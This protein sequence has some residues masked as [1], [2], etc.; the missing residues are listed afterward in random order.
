M[1]CGFSNF[2]QISQRNGRHC[3]VG[4]SSFSVSDGNYLCPP[5]RE[6]P[7]REPPPPRETAPPWK[8][9]KLP[10]PRTA[11]PEKPPRTL[12]PPR[13]APPEKLRKPPPTG[14]RPLKP[15]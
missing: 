13:T 9:R 1:T 3:A 15:G 8:L 14:A 2:A 5:P 4:R 11:P 6:P 12:P 7:P 10:P